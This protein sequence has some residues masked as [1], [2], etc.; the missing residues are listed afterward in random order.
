MNSYLFVNG[1]EVYHFKAKYSE[2]N[3]AP[4]YLGNIF[5]YL[6]YDK[7]KKT[8]LYG[9]V[10][11]FSVDYDTIDVA[12][13]LDIRKYNE[14][15]QYRIRSEF[16]VKM[17]IGLLSFC[18]I[19]EFGESLA[20]NCKEPLKCVTLNNLPYQIRPTLVNTNSDQRLKVSLSVT[21]TVNKCGGSCNT[22]IAMFEFVFQT[23]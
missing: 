16:M 7:I 17:F 15:T 11:D 3:A 12:G 22:M 19:K 1:V 9:Y 20:S 6:S 21:V 8:E 23:K 10:Y 4:S 14:K 5:R 2:I 18:T 13:I